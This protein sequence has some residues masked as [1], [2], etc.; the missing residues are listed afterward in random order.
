MSDRLLHTKVSKRKPLT[1][2]PK[3]ED[4]HDGD[5]QIVSIKGKGTYLCVKDKS[6]WKIS[7]KF[8]PRNKFDTHIF[9]EITTRKIKS[10]S[11]L[12]MSFGTISGTLGGEQ[13]TLPVTKLGDGIN[14]SI[15]STLGSHNLILQS[16]HSPSPVITISDSGIHHYFGTTNLT[17][18]FTFANDEVGNGEVVIGNLAGEAVLELDVT[19]ARDRY[20]RFKRTPGEG[21]K[22]HALGVDQTD[23]NFKLTYSTRAALS[24]SSGT[25]LFSVNNTGG[26]TATAGV[27]TT[28]TWTMDTSAGGTTGITQVNVGSAFTDSDTTLM[29]AGAIKE[30]IED[31]GYSTT[32]GDIT[33]VTLTGDSGGALADTS[34]SADFIIAGGTNCTSAGSGSTITLNVDDAFIKNNAADIMDV[35]DF[36]AVAALKI[37]ADQ[38]ATAGAEDSKGLWID[39]VRVVA[40]SGTALHN[41]IGIDL[42]VTSDSLGASIVKGMDI[43]VASGSS[44]PTNDQTAIGIDLRADG[45]DTNI[46]MIIQT[47]GTH[48]KLVASADSVNDYAT[49]SVVNTGDLTI[50]TFG[51]GTTDSD[52]TLDID[53]DIH[54]N[55]DNGRIFFED[56][57]AIL[58]K[59]ENDSGKGTFALFYSSSYCKIQV[60]DNRGA[61]VI[62]TTDDAGTNAGHINI[63]ADGHVEFDGCGVGFDRI[64]YE[65]ATNV[66]VDFKT[67]NKAHLDMTGGSI[68]GTLTLQFPVTSGNFVLVVQQDGSTRTIAAYAT[69]DAAGNAGNNDGG[70]AGKVRWQGGDSA[71][72]NP[73]DL[74]DGGNKRDILSFYWDADEEVCYG[75]ASLDF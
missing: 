19:A 64:L 18:S 70:T 75:V 27:T 71:G 32:T 26:I 72:S 57:S 15:L 42:D 1:H 17:Q 60:E 20:I 39:Y 73:P 48:L 9:D 10:Q 45:A 12:M 25:T 43:D 36:G 30:K 46:G 67:G 29:S 44:A 50:A 52:L 61:T 13:V 47:A 58:G 69:K 33:G 35:D 4:G 31:Y 54:L 14:T 38:P 55:S 68:S 16:G 40:P 3:K 37:D 28:G 2:F 74:T 65:D 21:N 51:D 56:D 41:D 66:T 34:G 24:A 8:N 11:N 23:Q 7:E 53:G 49:I 6:E 63:E 59:I 5:M 22:V 62:S